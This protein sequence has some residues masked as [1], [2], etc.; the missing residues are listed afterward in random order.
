MIEDYN[1]L[2]V[3]VWSWKHL[4][5]EKEAKRTLIYS[6]W[7]EAGMSWMINSSLKNYDHDEQTDIEKK[8]NRMIH[9]LS[10]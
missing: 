10:A 4:I 5:V 7:P 8:S 9:K 1:K 3:D 2:L 6:A